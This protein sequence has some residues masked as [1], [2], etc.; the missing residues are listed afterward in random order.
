MIGTAR[1][2]TP[3]VTVRLPAGERAI[4]SAYSPLREA[5]RRIA[6]TEETA[7][8]VLLGAG[9]MIDARLAIEERRAQSVIVAEYDSAVWRTILEYVEIGHLLSTGRLLLAD[10]E[11]TTAEALH[12]AHHA[13]IADGVGVRELRAWTGIPEHRERFA[14]LR[15]CVSATV[16]AQAEDLASYRRFGMRWFR[17]ILRNTLVD[18][19]VD[20][21]HDLSAH[22]GGRRVTVL[23]AGPTAEHYPVG[24]EDGPVIAV[25]TVYPMLRRRGIVPDA[26]VSVDAHAWSSLHLRTPPGRGTI[27]IA[28]LGVSPR[29]VAGARTGGWVPITGGHP[30]A[31]LLSDAGA[32][33]YA[34]TLP[35]STV[36]DAA[37]QVARAAGAAAI[38]LLGVDYGYPR[39]KS[40][41]RGTYHYDLFT[42]NAH[43]LASQESQFARFVYS[44][45]VGSSGTP[46]FF[47]LP[48]A[49]AARRRHIGL[50]ENDLS[51]KN[52][53]ATKNASPRFAPCPFWLNHLERIE[54]A[55]D[56]LARAG[57]LATPEIIAV[58]GPHAL[59]HL[60]VHAAIGSRT[61]T[62]E[63]GAAAFSA[64]LRSIRTIVLASLSRY[65]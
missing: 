54:E 13:A 60:P 58:G 32:V 44:R 12:T 8:L 56:R 26:V 53:S 39:A 20:R 55:T 37:I 23:G 45:V 14:E 1:D 17:H 22:L 61:A 34:L 52:Y 36:T 21:F 18:T 16:E 7:T 30:L 6:G 40:Y 2:G 57:D 31:R 46:P 41:A 42:R 19:P 29:L 24:T 11:E 63:R 3:I 51:F 65:C 28:D 27:L 62:G 43:R 50:I 33:V 49:E 25:D 64:T 15:R 4:H 5:A 47:P 48:G 59:A 9:A 35:Y 10:G 38:Q